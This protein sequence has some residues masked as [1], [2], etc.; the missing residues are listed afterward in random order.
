[1]KKKEKK[2]VRSVLDI[3]RVTR[4]KNYIDELRVYNNGL[5]LIILI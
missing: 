2:I 5:N 4:Q 1:M 3:S